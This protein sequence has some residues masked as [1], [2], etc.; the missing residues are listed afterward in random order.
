MGGAAG[1]V[2]F[3]QL[4]FVTVVS[5]KAER[6]SNEAQPIANNRGKLLIFAEQT[7]VLFYMSTRGSLSLCSWYAWDRGQIPNMAVTV[8]NR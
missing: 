3:L 7:K 8:P 6:R 5:V 2:L 1:V 4:C